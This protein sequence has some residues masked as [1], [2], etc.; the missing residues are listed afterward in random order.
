MKHLFNNLSEE[1]KKIILEQ[2]YENKDLLNEQ[3]KLT[4]IGQKVVSKAQGATARIGSS[5]QNL[6]S[7]I[8][9][10]INRNPDL[11]A[12]MIKI[13]EWANWLNKQISVFKSNIEKLG[14]DAENTKKADVYK[15]QISYIKQTV[16]ELVKVDGAL[17]KLTNMNK[18]IANNGG[19]Y[20]PLPK[21]K[22]EP[23]EQKP[24]PPP[25]EQVIAQK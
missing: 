12:D 24:Q 2:H 8:S 4:G 22:M 23:E 9:G 3:T 21:M 19:T 13:K 16:D 20:N 7:K 5:A 11:D 6:G 1:E 25:Q 15:T 14:K 17:D 18:T 10:G